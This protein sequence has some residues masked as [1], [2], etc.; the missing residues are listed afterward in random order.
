MLVFMVSSFWYLVRAPS[1]FGTVYVGSSPHLFG[2]LGTW[3]AAK[4]RRRPFILEVRDMWPESYTEMTGDS[5]GA[6]VRSMQWIA[7]LLYRRASRIIVLAEPNAERIV[8]LG[9][10]PWTV[11]HIPNGVDTTSFLSADLELPRLGDTD[12][13][14][15]V[16]AGAH[17]PANGLDAVVDACSL[18]QRNGTSNIRVVLVGDGPAKPDLMNLA[19][20]RGLTN[21][22]FHEPV[23]KAQVGPLLCTADAAL[24]VLAPVELFSYGVSPNKLYDY[25]A[26][27]LPV[28]T[29]V[30]GLVTSIVESAEAGLACEPGDAEALAKAMS[31][32]AD[33]V[34]SDPS[35]FGGGRLY[36]AS[37]FDR[38]LLT[39]RLLDELSRIEPGLYPV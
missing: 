24:M 29:N 39:G 34:R 8:E 7:K 13:F 5:T 30:P 6:F 36:V 27:G 2:A 15:F 3:A 32:V 19:R 20:E 4:V 21:L 14:T 33:R 25:L 37:N 22:S 38:R 16:Y 28:V 26:A 11:C 23:S 18:L 17:G 9:A 10:Q 35:A 31:Y 12:H 1:P